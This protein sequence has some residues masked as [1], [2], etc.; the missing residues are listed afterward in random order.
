MS[1]QEGRLFPALL[2]HWRGRRGLSQLDLAVAAEISSRHLS[3][4]ETGRAQPSREMILR[5]GSTLD[6]PLRDQNELLRAAG[7]PPAF[8][9]PRPATELPKAITAALARMSAVHEPFPLTVLD[10]GYDVVGQNAAATR[11]LG[12]FVAE[13]A[14]L[15]ERINVFA[16]LFDPRLARPFI[17]DWERVARAMVARL[18]REALIGS[19]AALEGLLR[20]LLNY[21]G[22]PESFRQPDLSAPL[23]PAFTL[24]L[25]RDDV[26]LAF[27]TTV[28]AFSAP[29]NVTLEELRIESYYPLDD[30]TA[31]ACERWRQEDS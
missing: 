27:M 1:K 22:V 2:R 5:L 25:R 4:L 29:G 9:E 30:E 16:L 17:V 20:T 14:A 21:P 24:R 26:T 28:T 3:F 18:H 7:H 11:L 31:E 13:P 12:R 8:A 19:D 6:V 10:R 15:P 23:E